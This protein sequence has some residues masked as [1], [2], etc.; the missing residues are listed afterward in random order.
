MRKIF[1][2]PGTWN[3]S[4]TQND[5]NILSPWMEK[6]IPSVRNLKFFQDPEW[7]KYPKSLDGKVPG[8]WKFFWVSEWEKCAKSQDEEIIL[9]PRW[10]STLSSKIQLNI[11]R[12][13]CTMYSQVCSGCTVSS[14]ISR[15]RSHQSQLLLKQLSNTLSGI[16]SD[17]VVEWWSGGE[18]GMVSTSNTLYEREQNLGG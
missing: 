15:L 13:K 4:K 2:V 9:S 14:Y 8:T 5:E 12:R 17:E 18:K 3:S 7:W 11:I 16:A 1:K 6:I 10:P